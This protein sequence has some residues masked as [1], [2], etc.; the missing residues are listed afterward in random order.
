MQPL[1]GGKKVHDICVRLR[2]GETGGQRVLL[3]VYPVTRDLNQALIVMQAI[4]YTEMKDDR[5]Q[6]QQVLTVYNF[7]RTAWLPTDVLVGLPSDFTALNG[8]Q[9]ITLSYTLF[10]AISA[11][12][13]VASAPELQTGKSR[14]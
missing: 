2:L 12:K 4:L 9:E 1:V 3:H 10:A 13:P 8:V 5:V 6:I 11:G 7:G 14:L